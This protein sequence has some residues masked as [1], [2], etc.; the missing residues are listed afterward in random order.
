[1]GHVN[2]DL[3][4]GTNRRSPEAEA[5]E[6]IYSK[7]DLNAVVMARQ[8]PTMCHYAKRKVIWFPPSSNPQL[9]MQG[10]LNHKVDFLVVVQRQGN[11]YL[12]TDE[13]SFAP[14]LAAHPDVFRLVSQAPEW[15]I[16]QVIRNAAHQ[17]ADSPPL[18]IPLEGS[19]VAAISC[20]K[21]VNYSAVASIKKKAMCP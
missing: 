3:N 15:R 7:T 14:L 20:Y 6:W 18:V 5:G 11:Y 21:T 8:V 12:P 1:M 13:D 2:L 9:L 17:N 4:S 16:F 10:I 19:T